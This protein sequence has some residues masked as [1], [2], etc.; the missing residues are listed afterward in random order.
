[1]C[2][3]APR[4]C[5]QYVHSAAKHAGRALGQTF[6]PGPTVPA[7]PRAAL[8]RMRDGSWIECAFAIFASKSGPDAIAYIVEGSTMYVRT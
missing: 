4:G 2:T 6:V 1:M 8:A 5:R 7:A 3:C